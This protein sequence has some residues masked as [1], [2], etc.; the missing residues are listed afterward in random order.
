M[1]NTGKCPKCA[2]RN[3]VR[4]PGQTGAVG[5]GNNIS[6]GSVIPTLVDVSRYLCSECGFTEEWIVDKE[7]IE[8]VVKKFK[9][10]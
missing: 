6:I 8:K 1:K 9:G 7:D 4:I 2:S 3:I 10:K 5:I